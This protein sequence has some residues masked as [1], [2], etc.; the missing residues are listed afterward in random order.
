MPLIG[1]KS[2]EEKAAAAARK[3]KEQAVV[4]ARKEELR[5]AA[6]D[7]RRVE[8]R[9][10]AK[11]I[12]LKSPAGRARLAFENGDH[13]FQYDFDVMSQKGTPVSVIGSYTLKKTS[14]PVAV[15]IRLDRMPVDR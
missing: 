15:L 7:R 13:V 14:D 12:F 9:E 10:K 1:R 8:E 3:K 11:E 5:R 4:A 2:E 6:D